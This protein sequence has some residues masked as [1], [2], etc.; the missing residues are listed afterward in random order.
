MESLRDRR[1]FSSLRNPESDNTKH[2]SLR[3][4]HPKA[5]YEREQK[6]LEKLYNIQQAK[7]ARD[8]KREEDRQERR[9][10][11][12]VKR[13]MAENRKRMAENRKPVTAYD[14][15][16]EVQL[17][18]DERM[19]TEERQFK[20]DEG[21]VKVEVRNSLQM[22]LRNI[23]VSL[24]KLVKKYDKKN[25]NQHI[26]EG[27]KKLKDK[28]EPIVE[29]SIEE[30][31]RYMM[32]EEHKRNYELVPKVHKSIIAAEQ[33]IGYTLSDKEIRRLVEEVVT[34]VI[35]GTVTEAR[36]D[37]YVLNKVDTYS[38]IVR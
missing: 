9:Y 11:K 20:T 33:E 16:R 19:R 5:E 36:I 8:K 10:N 24:D 22:S 4:Y 1:D 34:A 23:T 18:V 21:R 37:N 38:C 27:V 29:Q 28:I 17:A 25:G 30:L 14:I 31:A 6:R 15:L 2:N 32:E 26:A 3:A 13:R 12:A 7:A 35:Q